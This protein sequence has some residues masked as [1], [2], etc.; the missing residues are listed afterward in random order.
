MRGNRCRYS[1]K[2]RK[3]KLGG[4]RNLF[5]IPRRAPNNCEV[6]RDKA[7]DNRE[8]LRNVVQ[9]ESIESDV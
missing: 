5:I 4:A 7:D 6:K 1:A 3:K 8:S 9:I 2:Q